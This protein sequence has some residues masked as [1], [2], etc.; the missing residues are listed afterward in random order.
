MRHNIGIY[1]IIFVF[2][3][4]LTKYSYF[5]NHS[6]NIL[7]IFI[8]LSIFPGPINNHIS[9]VVYKSNNNVIKTVIGKSSMHVNCNVG[10]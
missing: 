3:L 2:I 6:I 9:Q 4:K 1:G 10:G 7:T 8:S 5:Q